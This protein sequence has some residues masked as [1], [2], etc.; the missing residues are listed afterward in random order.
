VFDL[1]RLCALVADGRLDCQVTLEDSWR[2]GSTAIEALRGR[3]IAGK[4]VLHID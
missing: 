2:N 3:Q 1:R 4:A